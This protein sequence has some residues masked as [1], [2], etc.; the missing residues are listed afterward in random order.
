MNTRRRW[1]G[2]I[3]LCASLGAGAAALTAHRELPVV[4]RAASGPWLRRVP[5]EGQDVANLLGLT[6]Y[7]WSYQLPLMA[8]FDSRRVFLTLWVEEWRR[9]SPRPKIVWLGNVWLPEA[10]SSGSWTTR[11]GGAPEV[12]TPD[13]SV[14]SE[15]RGK[16][17]LSLKL[18]RADVDGDKLALNQR[19]GRGSMPLGGKVAGVS[20]AAPNSIF[21]P[22]NEILAFDRDVTLAALVQQANGSYSGNYE[23]PGFARR[24]DRTVFVKV[25]FSRV[26]G[27]SGPDEPGF[28]TWSN[29]KIVFK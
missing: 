24:H 26:P 7:K 14:P 12:W 20:F 13:D 23:S 16:G 8:A 6:A 17:T 22:E 2:A 4:A 19:S 11:G 27:D 28:P 5:L 29:G 1:M 25:R 10:G 18:P 9:S 21:A 3:A 15:A